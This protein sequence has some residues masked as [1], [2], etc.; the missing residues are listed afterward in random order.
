ML[1]RFLDGLYLFAGYAAGAF[2]VVIFAHH[3]GDVG[4]AAVRTQHSGRRRLRLVVHGRDGVSRPRAHLQARR[5][6]PRRAAARAVARA[7]QAGRSR[8]SRSA[9]RRP[10]SLYFTCHA[11]Q[12]TYESWR[13]NDMAQG[14]LA[15]PLWIPQLGYSR[16]PRHPVDRADRRD[17][18]RASAATGR[19]YEKGKPDETPEEIRRA[20]RAG[21][22]RLMLATPRPGRALAHPARAS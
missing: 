18:Q 21:R 22:R 19:R 12:M 1:R 7:Q 3:D 15:M 13:F 6:D 2:L 16:R 11:V 17:G 4:R 9:S 5:D 20:H 10:S 14:V 8:S